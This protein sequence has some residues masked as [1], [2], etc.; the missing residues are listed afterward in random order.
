MGR[1]WCKSWRVDA[2]DMW[3]SEVRKVR[4]YAVEQNVVSGCGKKSYGCANQVVGS[5]KSCKETK[6][7]L[8]HSLHV[9]S[10]TR[11]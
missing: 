5:A 11:H 7:Y 3:L 8:K 10:A 6:L 2:P 1:S 4:K 9:W